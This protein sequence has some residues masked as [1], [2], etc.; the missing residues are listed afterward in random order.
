[1][2]PAC[3]L[4]E[5]AHDRAADAEVAEWRRQRL[6]DDVHRGPGAIDHDAADRSPVELDD[7]EA[8]RRELRAVAHGLGAE[9]QGRELLARGRRQQRQVRSRIAEQAQAEREVVLAL[10]PQPQHAAR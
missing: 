9:L 10:G 5:G 3:L 1:M 6:V 8:R 4:H 7:V 2:R